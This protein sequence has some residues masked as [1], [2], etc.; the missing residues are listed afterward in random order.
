MVNTIPKKTITLFSRLLKMVAPPPNMTVEQWAAAYRYIPDEYGAHPGR[1][2]SDGAPYQKEPM[3]AFTQKGVHRVVMMCA[4]QL[5]KSEIMFNVLGRF[6]HLDP[7]PMLLVQPTLG[8]AQDWS[9]ERLAPT[10]AR[11]PVLSDL[12]AESKS[13]D[14]DN[15]ILKKMFPG[16]YLA[17]V[18]SNAPSGLAKRSIRVLLFDEVDRFEKSAGSE[19]DPVDLG[20]KRTSNFWNHIVGLFSTP[21]GVNSRIYREYMLGT[22]EEWLHKCPNCGEW[23]WV[24]LKDMDYDAEE[25]NTGGTKSYVVKSVVW[26]CPD[27]GFS[28]TESQMKN[29]PQRYIAKNPKIS[30][31]RSFHVNAF[32]SPWLGWR[33]LIN[34]YLTAKEDPE[35]M[36]TFVNTRLAELYTPEDKTQDVD[37]LM[38]R[39]EHYPAELPDGVLV[40]T[41]AVDTQDNRLEYEI[42]GWGRGEELWGIR[43]GIIWGV[44]D[45]QRTWDLLD[46][47]LDAAYHFGNGSGLKVSRVFIDHGGHYSD[48]VYYYCFHNR[49]KQRYAVQGAHEFGVPVMYKMGKAKGWPQLDLIILG[50][51]DGKQYVYQRLGGVESPGPGYMHFPDNE[52]KGYD[53]AYFNGLLAEELQTKMVNGQVVMKWVNIAKDKRNEP[54]DLKVYNLAC[55]RSLNPNWGEYEAIVNGTPADDAGKESAESEEDYGC[56]SRGVVV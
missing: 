49:Y 46:E 6:M 33:T 22:Q 36:K 25:I 7:C 39:R 29:A 11:T 48:A 32:A 17:L 9:K 12:V 41:A 54:I 5:G 56:I 3:K 52:D 50:V 53:R 21:S 16:G 40:L 24:T 31:R 42:C 34:E 8:D 45:Q 15:T 38:A 27:C 26:R 20:I 28:F 51:N 37:E 55:L 2:S 19:G 4:A 44:P 14:S 18:G 43:K 30:D 23:H 10:I 1:W 47:Q 13:R 35:M